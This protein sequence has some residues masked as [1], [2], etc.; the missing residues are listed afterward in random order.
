MDLSILWQYHK[1]YNIII[2]STSNISILYVLCVFI[3]K[4]CVHNDCIFVIFIKGGTDTVLGYMDDKAMAL[5]WGRKDSLGWQFIW[6]NP[7][8]VGLF[9]VILEPLIGTISICPPDMKLTLTTHIIYI[10]W[11]HCLYY[12]YNL[13]A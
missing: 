11:K 12:S 4:L 13:H 3:S 10:K 6:L 2:C 5:G 7:G 9:T 8:A 1:V